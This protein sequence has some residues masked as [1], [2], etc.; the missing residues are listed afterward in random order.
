MRQVSPR[1]GDGRERHSTQARGQGRWS[2]RDPVLPFLRALGTRTAAPVPLWG[3]G[4][5]GGV[6]SLTAEEAWEL[7]LEP[8]RKPRMRAQA[9]IPAFLV[10]GHGASSRPAPGS[11]L[12][13][14]GLPGPWHR[15]RALCARP[16]P[17]AARQGF[18]GVGEASR[19]AGL[20]GSA[21][22]RDGRTKGCRFGLVGR[23]P[24]REGGQQPGDPKVQAAPG[25]RQ[26]RPGMAPAL[27]EPG[28]RKGTLAGGSGQRQSHMLRLSGICGTWGCAL[29]R[30]HSSLP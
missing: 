8:I 11:Q 18:K 3:S 16:A 25:S 22:N 1:A 12:G 13:G 17:L 21:R 9:N 26:E 28:P 7:D 2:N 27:R 15:P 19:G 6:E 23:E 24:R 29:Q 5:L 10:P 20:A 30:I 14:K 4:G